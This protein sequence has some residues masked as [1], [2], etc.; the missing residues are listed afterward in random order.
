MPYWQDLY[1]L[2]YI[3]RAVYS[4][5]TIHGTEQSTCL[6]WVCFCNFMCD[7]GSKMRTDRTNFQFQPQGRKIKKGKGFFITTKVQR[8]RPISISNGVFVDEES[9][10]IYNSSCPLTVV[11]IWN[12][13]QASVKACVGGNSKYAFI[14][15]F[16]I[17]SEVESSRYFLTCLLCFAIYLGSEVIFT[18]LSQLKEISVQQI[19]DFCQAYH[20][21]LA[22]LLKN[23]EGV[24]S[25]LNCAF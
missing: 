21:F 3:C 19:L 20:Y 14:F 7:G 10:F 18:L 9:E 11:G 6:W 24:V 23:T 13:N 12:L 8:N 25:F 2:N 1:L 16:R 4:P 22:F 5:F 15:L 17:I